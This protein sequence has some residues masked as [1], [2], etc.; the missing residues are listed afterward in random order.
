MNFSGGASGKES[1]LNL[2][3]EIQEM[4]PRVGKNLGVGNS[5]PFPFSSLGKFYGQRSLAGSSPYGRK[6]L[7]MSE[8]T[9]VCVVFYIF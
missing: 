1:T 9:C 2:H 6:E 8:H 5:N 3:L 4:H 7:D